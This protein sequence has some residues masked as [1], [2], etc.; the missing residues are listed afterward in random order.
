MEEEWRIVKENDHYE[1]SNLG[2]V[3]RAD[4]KALLKPTLKN[5]GYYGVVLSF[6]MKKDAFVHRL[7]ASAFIE[8]PNHEKYVNHKDESKTNNNADNLEWCSCRYNI[9]YGKGYYSRHHKVI[10][11]DLEGNFVKEWSSLQEASDVLN[12]KY[13]SISATCRG[14]HKT[15]GGFK[16]EY[17][18]PPTKRRRHDRQS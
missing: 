2:R 7:V 14:K 12:I 10:Q 18:K 4:T 6:G 11:R 1:V 8:N 15:A 9:R 13:Q 16:W 3:R 17:V 5:T